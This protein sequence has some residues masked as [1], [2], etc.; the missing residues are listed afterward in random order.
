MCSNTK[1]DSRDLRAEL[2]SHPDGSA[3]EHGSWSEMLPSASCDTQSPVVFQNGAKSASPAG[4]QRWSRLRTLGSS[5]FVLF[6]GASVLV[7][8]PCFWQGRIQAG[9]LSS[10]LYNVWLTQLIRHGQV[11]GLWIAHQWNN[12]LFD[13]SLEW[14]FVHFGAQVAERVAVAFAVLIFFWGGLTLLFTVTTKR[15]WS[16]APCFAMLAYGYVFQMGFFN[17]Y[18]SLGLSFFALAFFWRSSPRYALFALPLLALAWTAHPLPVLWCL[19]TAG[20]TWIARVIPFRG[21]LVFFAI[22]VVLL[23]FLRYFLIQLPSQWSWQQL[24]RIT[25]ADQLIVY[26]THYVILG[27]YLLFLWGT[28]YMQEVRK[29][30]RSAF[31]IPVQLTLLAGAVT[32][33]LPDG[34]LFPGYSNPLTLQITRMSITT[35][36]LVCCVC[37]TATPTKFHRYAFGL[38]ALSFFACLYVDHRELNRVEDS[39]T[40]LVRQLPPEQRVLA[41]VSLPRARIQS[42]HMVDRACIGHCF[43]YANYEAPSGYFRV[44][45][46]PYNGVVVSSDSDSK[47]L[48][49]GHYLVRVSD[50]PLYQIYSCGQGNTN[51]CVRKLNAGEINGSVRF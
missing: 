15:P 31:S 23:Y 25:G 45:A 16:I 13:L 30:L 51:L 46:T 20:Y 1:Q 2:V 29:G 12:I 44:R 4:S 5:N 3:R 33:L 36:V 37:G 38:L 14:L 18:I 8:V 11:H 43:S 28:L 41:L 10:H 39:V 21:Q 49:A 9:D 17:F 47:A 27:I 42:A 32:F 48:Q 22:S 26:G 19:A 34:V 50:L 6:L 7:L 40:Q 35:A 24:A